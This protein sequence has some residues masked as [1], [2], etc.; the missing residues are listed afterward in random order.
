MH[1]H[2]IAA[3][4][5]QMAFHLIESHLLKKATEFYDLG[6]TPENISKAQMKAISAGL[7]QSTS[8]QD[9][10]KHVG[11]FLAKQMEKLKKKEHRTARKS[12]WRKDGTGAENTN[13]LGEILIE[14]IRKEEYLTGGPDIE[15]I[16]QLDVLR[17]FWSNVSGLYS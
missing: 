15:K 1:D 6:F 4:E 17:R 5:N 10:R 16:P 8:F 9:A 14:W 7:Q 11:D 12:S 2:L 3:L 13:A